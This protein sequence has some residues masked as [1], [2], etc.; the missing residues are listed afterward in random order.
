VIAERLLTI[1]EYAALPD[2][3]GWVTELVRGLVVREPRPGYEHGRIQARIVQILTNHIDAHA[4]DLV[5]VG[6]FGVVVEQD[7]ATVRGPD[8]AVI[9]RVAVLEG[10]TEARFVGEHDELTGGDLLPS[11]RVPVREIFR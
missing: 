4:P 8:L 1:D 9:R 10:P 6:D 3:D 5:C 7:P 11:L 2:D